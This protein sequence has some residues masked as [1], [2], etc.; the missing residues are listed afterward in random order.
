MDN[1]IKEWISRYKSSPTGLKALEILEPKKPL[2]DL[3]K[4]YLVK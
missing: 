1:K 3:N 2:I 4:V